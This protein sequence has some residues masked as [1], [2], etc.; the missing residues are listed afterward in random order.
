MALLDRGAALALLVEKWER[1]GIWVL[2]RGDADYPKRLK[3]YLGQ[4]APP[5]LY[6]VGTRDL[7]NRGGLAV[8]GSRD[9]T[10]ED[11]EFARRVGG[12]CAAEGIVVISGEAKGIDRDCLTGALESGGYVACV[13]AGA[14]GLFATSPEFR[15]HLL[16]RHLTLLSAYEPD[17][18]W[19]LH[20]AMERNRLLYGMSDAALV[21]ASALGTGGTWTGAE[22]ALGGGR[23]KVFVKAAG[24]T[25]P[26][27]AKLLQ[28]GGLPFPPEPWD[29]LRASIHAPSPKGEEPAESGSP[30]GEARVPPAEPTG[31][32]GSICDAYT[33]VIHEMMKLLE[34]PRDEKW[35]AEHLG[36]R[37][38]QMKDWLARA[39]SEGFV[40]RL[41]NPTR[42][43]ANSGMLFSV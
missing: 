10:V 28:M 25:A 32:A 22:Q 19:F 14:L 36:V 2:S 42:Y 1:S 4:A 39:E 16:G 24:T 23:V 3:K 27:N 37:G 11:G 40:T 38:S 29:N 26:G 7:L 17:A 35:L 33:L 31:T 15:H 34:R 13:L 21:V 9:R 8:V 18:R 6:G 30:V 20:T 41:K 5:L 12:R 43:L